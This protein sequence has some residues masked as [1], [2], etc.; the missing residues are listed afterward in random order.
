MTISQFGSKLLS[1]FLVPLYTSVLSL[2]DY[3]IYD[4][5]NTTITLLVPILTLC[6][7]DA[8]LR[9]PLDE[10]SDDVA[11]LTI[12]V[13]RYLF[14]QVIILVPLIANRIF[15]FIPI[16][17]YYWVFLIFMY[18]SNALSG[19][20]INFARGI[21][22]VK[23]VGI[24]GVI[25]SVFML[26]LNILF[27]LPLKMGLT[28]YFLANIIGSL[29]QILYLFI[30][31]KLWKYLNF[32]GKYQDIR[33]KMI[34]YSAP[35]IANTTAWW[36]NNVSDRYVV[37]WISGI[38]ANGVYSVAYKIPTILSAFQGIFNQAWTLSAVKEF[39][40][41]DSKGFFC[42]IY[43]LYNF[44]MV[45]VCSGLIT[46][47]R[48]IAKIMFAKDF[49]DA[50][51]FVP[52]LLIS[53]VF[54]A[55]SGYLGGIFAAVKNTKIFAQTTVISAII[56]IVL[57]I[58]LVNY[59][60]PLGAALA[61]LISY[62]VIYVVRIK[63]VKKYISIQLKIMRDTCSYLVL[64]VQAIILCVFKTESLLLY[65]IEFVFVLVILLLYIDEVTRIMNM[66]LR[67]LKRNE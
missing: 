7:S 66:I 24:S 40:T 65:F 16:I 5:Y 20:F 10:D 28:G 67:R 31:L 59:I 48:L 64:L 43:N 45:F 6:L 19:I 60:G 38:A 3:G 47:A 22:H 29:V 4:L 57:N 27:L 42:E 25:C 9:F 50:W 37:T 49:Y 14:G 54:G 23:E 58:V 55:L 33:E 52:W 34:S 26:G 1:F 44:S 61:T 56:N 46:T 18:M 36:V 53:V 51:L 12:C 2:E 11:V 17:N 13:R 41:E 32:G 62:W 8:A 21:D 35:L 39:D 63:Y 30:S 15:N